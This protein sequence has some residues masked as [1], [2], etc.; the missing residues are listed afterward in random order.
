MRSPAVSFIASI[1]FNIRFMSTCCNW[2]RSA[3]TSGIPLGELGPNRDRRCGC[4]LLQQE[5][6]FANH[7]VDVH[8]LRSGVVPFMYSAVVRLMI[9]SAQVAALSMREAAVA[10]RLHIE[11]I[12]GERAEADIGVDQCGGD[13]LLDFVCERCRTSPNTLTLCRRARAIR[14]CWSSASTRIRASSARLRSDRSSTKTNALVLTFE[15]RSTNQ[16]GHAAAVLAD[17]VPFKRLQAP[18]ALDLCDELLT[19]AAEALGS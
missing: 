12:V 7:R 18:R 14:A 17:V 3:I 11:T 9:S 13:R 8:A 16:Y 10:C 5:G 15:A 6:H 2:T 19:I 4:L 1:A